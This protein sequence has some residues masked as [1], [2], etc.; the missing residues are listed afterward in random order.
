V[1]QVVLRN[2]QLLISRLVPSIEEIPQLA[3]SQISTLS[4]I[5]LINPTWKRHVSPTV[6]LP[7]P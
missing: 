7:R 5:G 4:I 3:V 2:S 1:E 6:N